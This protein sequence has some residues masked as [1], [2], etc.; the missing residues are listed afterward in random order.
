MTDGQFGSLCIAFI[1]YPGAFALTCFIDW[2][3]GT[4]Q[5]WAVKLAMIGSGWFALGFR[6]YVAWVE[7]E[8]RKQRQVNP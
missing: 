1:T 8:P 2:I 5:H 4:D 7:R 6:E 3:E